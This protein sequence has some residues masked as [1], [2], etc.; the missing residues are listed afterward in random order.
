MA[1][2]KA[3]D[4]AEIAKRAKEDLAAYDSRGA[5]VK[6]KA[7]MATADLPVATVAQVMATT[8]Q[9]VLRWVRAYR[10][11]GVDALLPRPKRP[12]RPKLSADQRAAVLSWLDSESTASGEPVHWTLDGLRAAIAEEFGVTLARS[13]IWKWLRKEGRKP[14]VPRPRHHLADADAQAAFKKKRRS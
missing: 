8:L 1:R 5:A 13:A 14:K 7:I 2:P 3:A 4:I 12:R 6:L 9:T 10:E 11:G